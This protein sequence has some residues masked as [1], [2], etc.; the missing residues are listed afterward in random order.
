MKRISCVAI[1]IVSFL[2]SAGAQTSTGSRYIG[3][4]YQSPEVGELLP[5]GLKHNG[6]GLIGD[7]DA[8]PVYGVSV[9]EKGKTKMFWL[10]ISTTRNADGGVTSWQ[11][12]DVLEFSGTGPNDFVLEFSEPTFECKRG[13]AIVGNLVGIGVFNRKAGIFTPRKLWQPN[14][15]TAKFEPVSVKSIRCY[16]SEP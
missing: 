12:K 5:N 9:L 15:K 7:I 13:K 3:Y 4:K 6:G 10:E 8:D 16:Y 11:V 1:V 2:T 14:A